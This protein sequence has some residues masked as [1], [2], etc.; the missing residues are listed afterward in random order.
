MKKCYWTSKVYLHKVFN[1]PTK[2]FFIA[3]TTAMAAS[4]GLL[5]SSY[6][7]A[8]TPASNPLKP[9]TAIYQTKMKGMSVS[10]ERKLKADS[11]GNYVLSMNTSSMM[12]KIKESSRF[13]LNKQQIISQHYRYEQSGAG[14]KRKNKLSF[15]WDNKITTDKG[16]EPAI[17]LEVPEG[18]L[19]R[20][21]SQLQIRLDL[22]NPTNKELP[23]YSVVDKKRLKEYDF[24][25]IGEELL[26]TPVG[27]LNTVKIQ[28]Q[29]AKS[30]RK[31]YIWYA[32][33][34]DYFLVKLEQVEDDGGKYE[35]NLK[36]ATINGV[37]I[38]GLK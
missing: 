2:H 34:W 32:K 21:N 18:T 10:A 1:L 26:K 6:T 27:R 14:K 9:Y 24:E 22:A 35:L 4:I 15:D 13:R 20:L 3:I 33:D 7:L 8:D 23:T 31:T 36:E 5:A 12:V 17:S 16:Y 28:R 38:S 30:K 29:R 25:I 11:D 19:D 37:K